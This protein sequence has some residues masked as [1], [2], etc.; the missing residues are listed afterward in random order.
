M[1]TATTLDY[2][3]S[4][5]EF[6]RSIADLR[7]EDAFAAMDEWRRRRLLA[8]VKQIREPLKRIISAD[9]GAAT[10]DLSPEIA[11]RAAE[12]QAKWTK[13]E[14]RSRRVRQLAPVGTILFHLSGGI[15]KQA[16]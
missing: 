8:N 2:S 1:A 5:A 10:L 16:Q 11:E 14:R 4:K 3:V 7:G 9:H 15:L 13:R 6:C 12:V